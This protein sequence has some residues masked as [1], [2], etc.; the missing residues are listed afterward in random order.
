M[1]WE[2]NEAR[3]RD[4]QNELLK[5]D[6]WPPCPGY[7]EPTEGIAVLYFNIGWE[8]GK[9]YR[10]RAMLKGRTGCLGEAENLVRKEGNRQESLKETSALTSREG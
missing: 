4:T 8:R 6:A 5:W 7:G 3:R 1:V 9:L 2:Q 10:A